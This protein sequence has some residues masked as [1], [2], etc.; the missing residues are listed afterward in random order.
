[1]DAGG[2]TSL[3][4]DLP[5][6]PNNEL[7]TEDVS[8]DASAD[9]VLQV[10]DGLAEPAIL[11]GHSLG[12]VTLSEVAERVPEQV[13]ALVYVTA[14]MLHN[15]ESAREILQDDDSIARG[16][17]TISDDGLTSSLRLDRLREALCADCSTDDL[18]RTR[19]LVVP[20]T[21]A[22]ARTPVHTTPQRFGLVPRFYVE[23]RQDR[24]IPL[25]AQRRMVE[26][27]PCVGVFSMDTSHSPFLV[28]PE[29]LAQHILTSTRLSQ[30]HD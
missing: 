15:G 6:R 10:L 12:G 23:C 1:M 9:H 30:P 7:A 14:F 24:I 22:V 28:A 26:S 4:I 29:Q 2:H 21:L 17:R 3:A 18:E 8:L 27:M 16:S 19:R 25:H 5:G 13:R 11:V 20:E